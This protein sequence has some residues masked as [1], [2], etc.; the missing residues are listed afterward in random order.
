[1]IDNYTVVIPT[2]EPSDD[3]YDVIKGIREH[4]SKVII[5]N[6]GSSEKF[7][8][9]FNSLDSLDIIYL[10]YDENRG[11]GEALKTAFRYIDEHNY[12]EGVVTADSDGQHA[13]K[14]IIMCA[15]ESMEHKGKL[16]LG[17]RNFDQ[18]NVP[19]K[20]EFGNKLTRSILK[21][22]YGIK[23]TDSQTG[24]R[25]FS[26]DVMEVIAKSHGDRF[27]YE[28]N[29]LIDAKK[30]K[31]QIVEKTIETIYFENNEGTHFNPIVDSLK[32]YGIF[33]KYIL[34]S[35]SSFA[36]DFLM[37]IIF[38]SILNKLN[39]ES[40]IAI[41]TA[42]VGARIISSLFNYTVNK[43]I[44]FKDKSKNSLYRY[45]SLVVFAMI[46]SSVS[47][48]ILNN[49]FGAVVMMKIIADVAIF[50]M[51]YQIQKRWVYR[52]TK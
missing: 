24:L 15:K 18:E 4:F 21:L 2:Y 51:N 30:N 50:L 16:I 37:F 45:F 39:V 31:I 9:I 5:V 35:V 36:L 17:V 26:T 23:I 3:L 13:V 14:D 7:D 28:T 48:T 1:M 42:T 47:V 46:L 29:M 8:A 12:A 49:L 43:E 38:L 10:K 6:D 33:F 25:A 41:P 52:E 19:K 22:F 32:I 44:V 40:N 11:K 34:S 27:E 20:S